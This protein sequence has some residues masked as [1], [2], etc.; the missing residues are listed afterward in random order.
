MKQI[1]KMI[2]QKKSRDDSLELDMVCPMFL[3]YLFSNP[4]WHNLGESELD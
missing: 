2:T 3:S 1:F 4:T